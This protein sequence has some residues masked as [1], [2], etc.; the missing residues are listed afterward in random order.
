MATR[1]NFRHSLDITLRDGEFTRGGTREFNPLARKEVHSLDLYR[2]RDT[3][4]RMRA[5]ISEDGELETPEP[6]PA[7]A[8][9]LKR[10][11]QIE[12]PRLSI[13]I[14]ETETTAIEEVPQRRRA[15]TFGTG[16]H[17]PPIFGST[18]ASQRRT[19]KSFQ[20]VDTNEKQSLRVMV[21]S[22]LLPSPPETPDEECFVEFPKLEPAPKK[23][24]TSRIE[25][26]SGIETLQLSG[27]LPD[28]TV[29]LPISPSTPKPEIPQKS[30]LRTRSSAR[31]RSSTNTSTS[32]WNLPP[33]IYALASFQQAPPSPISPILLDDS[34]SSPQ[35]KPHSFSSASPYYLSPVRK[36][37]NGAK[38]AFNSFSY[39]FTQS[40]RFTPRSQSE[41]GPS[42][43]P[44]SFSHTKPRKASLPTPTQE[45][46]SPTASNNH[47]EDY[48]TASLNLTP[49]A[50]SFT[51]LQNTEKVEVCSVC[52]LARGEDG[53]GC[54]I[55]DQVRGS[56][57]SDGAGSWESEEEKAGCFG[58]RRLMRKI[59]GSSKAGQRR[60]TT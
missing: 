2:M 31:N 52:R 45:P 40:P 25:T 30:P 22:V 35:W 3:V 4:E 18:R 8:D 32:S 21:Q 12:S 33:T 44:R 23:V 57:R 5:I 38:P 41:S 15:G 51:S 16:P 56:L 53:C 43:P 7:M 47:K 1:R 42:G 58:V 27:P 48:F 14:P 55:W 54:I 49:Y 59:K 19:R 37:I 46:V 50:V 29:Q 36:P 39:P 24:T 34:T 6:S 28:I 11:S 10:Y 20:D 17:S 9:L 13:T 60:K 26:K